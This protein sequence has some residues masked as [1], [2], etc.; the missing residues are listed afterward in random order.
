MTGAGGLVGRAAAAAFAAKGDSVIGLTRDDLD[1]SDSLAVQE[2]ISADSPDVVV[3]CAA[4][5]DVDGCEFDQERAMRVN[6]RGPELLAIACRASDALLIT[7]STDYVFDGTKPGF[8]TQRDQPNPQSVYAKSKLEGEHRPRF[9]WART[10]IVRSGYIFGEGGGNYLSRFLEY[11]RAGTP[12]KAINDCF[13]TP[14]YAPHLAER[15]CQLAQIDLPGIYHVVNAGAGVSFSDFIESGLEM[16]GLDPALVE[17]ISMDSLSRP[18]AR[19]RNSRLQCLLSEA[20]GLE[21]MPHWRDALRELI[22]RTTPAA[23]SKTP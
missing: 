9:D 22:D 8:Y 4:W 20:I 21:E 5:T 12:L 23:R 15:L 1:V 3:N 11:A 2:Q 16:A 6:A 10:I 19:P 18:A 14:T 13:G 7:I 17:S